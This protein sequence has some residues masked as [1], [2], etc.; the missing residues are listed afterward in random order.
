MVIRRLV[1]YDHL[2]GEEATAALNAVY[3]LLRLW[4]NFFQPSVKLIKKERQG[5]KVRKKYD[6]AK[7]PLPACV[8]VVPCD[9]GR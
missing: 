2:E 7:T 6:Q 9:G 8:G 4:N 3:D 5:A 1:G